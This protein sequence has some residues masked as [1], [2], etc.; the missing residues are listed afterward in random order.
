MLTPERINE[1][2]ESMPG[3]LGGFLKG[4]GWQ[5][6]AR[7]IEEEVQKSFS[8]PLPADQCI[9]LLKFGESSVTMARIIESAHGIKE[10]AH[11]E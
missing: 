4:W 3:G 7:A 8:T 2:A 6:F 10:A 5:Q 11:A 9:R 1:I